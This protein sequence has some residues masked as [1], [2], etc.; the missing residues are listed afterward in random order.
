MLVKGWVVYTL[1]VS[2]KKKELWER[3]KWDTDASFRYFQ[4]YYL[5]QTPTRSVGKAY[6]N[7]RLE[8]GVK[9]DKQKSAPG[10][11]QNWAQAKNYKGKKIKNAATWAER[12]NAYNDHLASQDIDIWAEKREQVRRDDFEMG[13]TLRGLAAEILETA[14]EYVT[15]TTRIVKGKSGKPDQI[16]ITRSININDAVKSADL[17][18]K[19]QRLASGL[20]TERTKGEVTHKI[21]DK[22]AWLDSIEKRRDDYK[23]SRAKPKR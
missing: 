16:V 12:A 18:S 10:A 17:A 11:W 13:A 9:E 22:D 20:E 21:V 6:R 23:G 4:T 7:A 19:L 15:E 8:K 3:Q 5:S 2:K 1:S 14:P